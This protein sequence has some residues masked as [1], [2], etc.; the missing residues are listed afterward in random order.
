MDVMRTESRLDLLAF[1]GVTRTLSATVP[2]RVRPVKSNIL[3]PLQTGKVMQ[4]QKLRVLSI[5]ALLRTGSKSALN[6]EAIIFHSYRVKGSM[7][8][9]FKVREMGL[10]LGRIQT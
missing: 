4:C 2:E 8:F 10:Y 7:V 5:E 3:R 9:V 6:E 1:C